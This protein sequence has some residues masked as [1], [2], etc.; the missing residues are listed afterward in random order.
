MTPEPTSPSRPAYVSL[1]IIAWNEA[2]ALPAT[3]E[4]LFRQSLFA[5]LRARKRVCELVCVANGCTDGTAAVAGGIFEEQS[6]LHP[7]REGFRARVEELAQRGKVNAWNHFVHTLSSP[8][9]RLLFLMDADIRVHPEETL[10]NMLVALETDGEANVAVDQPQKDI[11]HKRRRSLGEGLSLAAS[12]LAS[13]SPAQ[14]CGQLYCIRA[15]VARN[16]YLPRD[17][18]ACEDGFIKALVCTDF[19]THATSP[20]RIRVAMGAAHTFEAYTTPAAVVK[21]QKR[22]IMGQTMVHILVDQ[23][24]RTLPG[25][26]RARMAETLRATD[27]A[28]PNWLKRLVNEHLRRTRFFWRLY[29]GL[30]GNRFR[31]LGEQSR[32][33]RL[34][35]LPAAVAGVT[36]SLISSALAHR[37]LKRGCTDYWPRAGR[38]GNK[39]PKG[40]SERRR[41]KTHEPGGAS[42]ARNNN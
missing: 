28:E 26:A 20:K 38:P 6:H 12:R 2:K 18:A 25:P 39:P 42:Y 37:A 1:G 10:W 35:C 16:I 17:L 13:A 24:L 29:P 8:E 23:Y 15:E 11:A 22:Q 14:L 40:G 41:R 3:L 7:D 9:A 34:A 32:M 33:Q 21:N 4:A 5:E 31:R 36:V 30:L 27:A 19:L